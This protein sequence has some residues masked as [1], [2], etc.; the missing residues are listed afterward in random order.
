MQEEIWK[1][2]EGY[3]GLYQV[4]SEGRVKS[5]EQDIICKN[6]VKRHIKERIIECSPY[7]SEKY[8]VVTLYKGGKS[9]CMDVD[10]LVANAFIPNTE[11]YVLIKHKNKI[12]TDNQ[13]D[14]LEWTPCD[15]S[16]EYVNGF[17]EIKTF[18]SITEA[19]QYMGYSMFNI[20]YLARHE[21]GTW[22]YV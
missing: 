9:T 14:N 22:K 18:S 7:L 5:L 21:L 10:Y 2:I 3:E 16:V 1:D 20:V 13:V 15:R 8:T 12:T 6:G 17:G 11:N 4:S 19:A